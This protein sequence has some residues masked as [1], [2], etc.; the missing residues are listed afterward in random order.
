[1]G[2]ELLP[3]HHQDHIEEDAAVPQGQQPPEQRL[4]VLGAPVGAA[5]AVRVGGLRGQLAETRASFMSS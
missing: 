2:L 5:D 1:M 3:L 4:G